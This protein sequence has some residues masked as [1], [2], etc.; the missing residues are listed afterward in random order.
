MCAWLVNKF[1]N[2]QQKQDI[3]TKLCSMEW[4]S[5]YCL[6]EP[7]SGSDASSLQTRAELSS[8]GSYYTL[9]GSKAFISG[10]GASDIYFIM[11]RT[12]GAGPKGISC[13]AVEKDTPGLSFG[14][15]EK[16][17]GW[18]SQP[19][20]AVFLEDCKVPVSNRIGAEGD[21]FKIAMAALDGG[22]LSIASCSL[23]AATRCLSLARDHV[24]VRKQ[25]G[26]PLS[27]NQSI[28]FKLADM[29]TSLHAGRLM[30][31][32]AARMLDDQYSGA[33]PFCAMA[34]RFAT[35]A[36][37]DI[38]ND[39]LQL[40]GGYGFLNDYPIE[41]YL[42]DVRVHQILEGTNQIMQMIIAREV[43]KQK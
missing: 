25:F 30:V 24:L 43:T 32:S 36:G 38:C 21:G 28:Q 20:A 12:G 11:V 33:T 31:R 29:A 41:R 10:G 1:G 16:K 4:F 42:R 2:E 3:L 18:N 17:M 9:N 8:D 7:S 37:F 5:S 27:S 14:A 39:A 15:Q 6:T 40:H 23:G 13:V 22:R 34:K 35:D 26:T 19:T